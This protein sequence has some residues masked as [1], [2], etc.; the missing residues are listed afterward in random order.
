MDERGVGVQLCEH[1]GLIKN[2]RRDCGDHRESEVLI[3]CVCS[4]ALEKLFFF[5]LSGKK[6]GP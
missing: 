4:C 3:V 5:L 2:L 1:A 6:C